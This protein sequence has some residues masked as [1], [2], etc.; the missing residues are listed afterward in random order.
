M[1]KERLLERLSRQ[2]QPNRN[3]RRPPEDIVKL[4]IQGYLSR[5]LN[6]R[7]GSVPIDAEYGLPD[8]S[9][10]AGS[11]AVGYVSEIQRDILLQIDLYEKRLLRP[12]IQQVVE[13]REIITL[14]FILTGQLDV[15]TIPGTLMKEFSMFLRI[16]AAGQVSLEPMLGR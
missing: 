1:V 16:N 8:M 9:N 2:E 6:V 3:D 7:R 15:G 11:F 4:S 5:L 12:T 13:E 14:K 10:I